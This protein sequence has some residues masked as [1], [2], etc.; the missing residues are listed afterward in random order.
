[1]RIAV[2]S[3]FGES[4]TNFRGVLL[5]PW[6]AKGHV[7]RGVGP[8]DDPAVRAAL[9]AMGVA[10]AT[11]PLRRAGTSPFR[12]AAAVVSLA[13]TFRKF[14]ADAVLAYAAKPVIYGSIAARV[15]GVPLR[16]AMITGVGSAL[17]GGSGLRRRALAL[18]LRNLYAVALRQDDVVFFQNPDDERLFR[19]TGLVG[20]RA[21][22][23][24]INGSGVDLAH[25]VPQPLGPPPITFLMIGRLIRDKGVSEYVE[26]ARRVRRVHPE[27]RVQLLGALDPNPSAISPR[28]LEEWRREGVIEYLGTTL[29]VRPILA[30]AHIYVLPSYGEGMPRSVLE[31]MAMGR[32][33]LTTDVPGCRETVE[34]GRNGLLVPPRDAGALADGMLRML[35]E[36]GRLGPMG[37]RSRAIAEE[38]FDVHS[39]NR[40][41]LG[42]LG[43]DQTPA[44]LSAS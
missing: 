14:R 30:G 13:R 19:S 21:R 20:R 38:R 41:I 34:V 36:P 22:V 7:V 27:V 31:A 10:Y 12:D 42:A 37:R 44:G 43:L 40:T 16:A 23:V 11:V 24:R 5:G 18:L 3:P 2:V 35:A 28:Q 6:V 29:D 9:E 4:L 39:V 15:A 32:P 26:A 1:V 17:G 8:E 25:F 33:V